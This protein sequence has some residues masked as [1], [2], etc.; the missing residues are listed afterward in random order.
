M[1]DITQGCAGDAAEI[2]A[3]IDKA[4]AK[5]NWS[6]PTLCHRVV[7]DRAFE[8]RLDKGRVTIRTMF[9]ARAA[10]LKWLEEQSE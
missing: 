7:G 1:E 3:L 10:L 9:V 5:T 4:V 6:R 2:V 8:D